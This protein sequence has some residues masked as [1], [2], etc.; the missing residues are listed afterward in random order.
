MTVIIVKKRSQS[1]AVKVGIATILTLTVI[2]L[3][4]R[5]IKSGN[6][7]DDTNANM[8][9]VSG[10]GTIS[11]SLLVPVI[12]FDIAD[13]ALEKNWIAVLAEKLGGQA[14]VAV[15]YGRVDV[16]TDSYAIEVEYIHK[17]KEGIGQAIHYGEVKGV[18]PGLA[19]IYERSGSE[20]DADV[21]DKIR[22]IEALCS[23]KGIRLFLLKQK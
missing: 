13:P 7:E 19:I 21:L 10:L 9:L 18:T 17:F 8:R 11:D 16:I 1:F 23:A 12:E 6:R 20:T 3:A 22:H 5:F 15:P 4:V 14:E 2:G